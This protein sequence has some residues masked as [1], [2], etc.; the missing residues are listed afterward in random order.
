MLHWILAVRSANRF[1]PSARLIQQALKTQQSV[2]NTGIA[3]ISGQDFVHPK[4][5]RR[6]GFFALRSLVKRALVGQ[7][8]LQ[9]ISLALKGGTT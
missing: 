2:L 8:M 5:K 1:A 3:I 6:L 7:S 4:R 9:V